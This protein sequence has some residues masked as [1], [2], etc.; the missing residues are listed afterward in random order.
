MVDKKCEAS[1]EG[2]GDAKANGFATGKIG[3]I[4]PIVFLGEVSESK[5]N[6][7][8]NPHE[9]A[10]SN[11]VGNLGEILSRDSASLTRCA[12]CITA[13]LASA[14]SRKTHIFRIY[15]YRIRRTFYLNRTNFI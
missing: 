5:H 4:N 15:N 8:R 9:N 10:I 7:H 3:A 2:R 6:E 12:T 14:T 11:N 1:T 13:H